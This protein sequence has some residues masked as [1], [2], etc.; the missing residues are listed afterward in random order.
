MVSI[1]REE[2]R[3][4]IDVLDN[5]TRITENQLFTHLKLY[6]QNMHSMQIKMN[7]NLRKCVMELFQKAD[8]MDYK[9]EINKLFNAQDLLLKDMYNGY[10]NYINQQQETTN[11]LHDQLHI[12][13]FNTFFVNRNNHNSSNQTPI[14]NPIIKLE[15]NVNINN[16][17]IQQ[18]QNDDINISII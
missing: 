17:T 4:Y 1:K 8:N 11:K 7:E 9:H 16:N 5:T 6:Q 14:D 13:W 10:N 3:L 15:Q 2:Y 18:T 12:K